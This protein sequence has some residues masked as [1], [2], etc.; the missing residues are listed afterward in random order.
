M[1]GPR[2]YPGDI[3]YLNEILVRD[4]LCFHRHLIIDIFGVLIVK[5]YT[6]IGCR[7]A[8]SSVLIF[9]AANRIFVYSGMERISSAIMSDVKLI[10]S[11]IEPSFFLFINIEYSMRRTTVIITG[12]ADKG[13][14]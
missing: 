7:F 14:N 6:S 11:R 9:I 5:T 4:N 1:T 12:R 13:F 10:L 3:D 2:Y 8:D